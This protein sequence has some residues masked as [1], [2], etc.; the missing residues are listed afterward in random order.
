MSPISRTRSAVSLPSASA[1]SSMSWIWPRPWIVDIDALGALLVPAHRLAVL[2]G[3]RHAQQF[4]GVDVELGAEPTAD[5]RGDD[6]HLVLGDA[7]RERRHDL[8]DVRDLGGGVQRHVAAERLRHGE[9]GARFHRCRDQPLLDEALLGGER[10]GGEGG[11]DR[12]L[13]RLDLEVPRVALV[14]AEVGWMTTRSDSAS[15]RSIT[16][17]CGV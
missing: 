6:A 8:E 10:G 14:G 12:A 11:V 13:G 2:A 15:S 5:R 7:E 4:L 17:S 16:A 3:E 1:A 9:H